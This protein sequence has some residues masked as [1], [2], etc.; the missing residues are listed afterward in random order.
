MKEEK[1]VIPTEEDR[2][3]TLGNISELKL[4]DDFG[5]TCCY[6]SCTRC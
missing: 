4:S 1:I 6:T 5:E 3:K 2:L